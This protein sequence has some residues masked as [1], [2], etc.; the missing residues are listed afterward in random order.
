MY[1]LYK[2]GKEFF[3]ENIDLI[4]N[5]PL[6]TM[7][8]EGNANSIEKCNE[9]NYAARVEVDGDVLIAI[10]AHGYPFVVYGSEKC[11]SELA[12]IVV[13]NKLQFN[14]VIGY[15]G[16]CN[17]FLTEY[18]QIVGG[19][20]RINLSMD[21]MYC[22]KVA[23]CDTSA[24]EQAT[25]KDGE[26]IAQLIVEFLSEAM[27]EKSTWGEKI[28]RILQEIRYFALIRADGKIVSI[29]RVYECGNGL[30]RVSDVYTKPSY[31]NK[32]YAR[33][34]VTYLTEQIVASGDMACLHVDQ[35]NPV[36]NHLYQ[37]IG[38]KY[39]ESRYEFIY[40]RI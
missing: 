12:Q 30:C 29:A 9:E 21:I 33:K 22:D 19:T 28:Q 4:R 5:D 34:L 6:G 27:C 2:T 3:D 20:H 7:F 26:E 31:R 37:T 17:K 11:T 23:P 16:V 38:Y 36:S 1:K 18:E 15:H 10:R 24:V 25:A 32:G 14:K 40:E 35:H 8:F 13:K 39:G